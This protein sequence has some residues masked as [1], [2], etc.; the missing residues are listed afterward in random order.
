MIA[1]FSKLLAVC[2]VLLIASCG[3]HLGGVRNRALDKMD[4]ICVDMFQ[5]QTLYPNVSMQ[6]TTALGDNLQRDGGFRLTSPVDADL[7]ITGVVESVSSTSL[8]TDAQ[9]TYLSSEIGLTVKVRYTVTENASGKVL[10]SGL[11][12]AQGSFFNDEGNIQTARDSALSYATRLAAE[13]IVLD[14]TIP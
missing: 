14:L 12:S 13:K 6:L 10:R 8:R 3:Y 7:V 1:S 2:G 9:N 5:N 11:V 4:T